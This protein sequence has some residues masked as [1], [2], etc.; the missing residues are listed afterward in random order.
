MFDP[1]YTCSN[2]IN[3]TQA[4]RQVQQARGRSIIDRSVQFDAISMRQ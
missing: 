4:A 2:T 1:V 3:P